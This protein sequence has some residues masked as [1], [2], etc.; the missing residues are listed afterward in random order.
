VLDEV[1][2]W[3]ENTTPETRGYLVDGG[4]AVAALLGGHV[5]GTVVTRALGARNFD[6]VLRLSG[7]APAGDAD[8]GFT[9]TFFAGLL[10]RLTAWVGGAWW[11]A[12]KHGYA[13]L[14]ATLGLV[15]RRGWALAAV[16][17]AALAL[18]GLLARR[19]LDCL[20]GPAK[21]GPALNGAAP[22]RGAAGAVAAG[23]YGLAVVLVLLVAADS[24][25]WPLTRSAALALWQFAQHLLI[26]CAALSIGCLGARWAQDLVAAGGSSS[27]E[28]SAGQYTGLGIVAATTV[29]AVTVLLSSAGVLIGL[30]A[31]ALL[32]VPLWLGRGHLPDVMAGLQLRAHKVREVW[33]EGEPWEVVQVGLVTSQVGRGGSFAQVQNRIVLEARMHGAPTEAAAR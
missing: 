11:L 30:A 1:T 29:L 28:K 15:L 18:G 24:F 4:L 3:W 31:L 8:R 17:V 7:P 23:A 12:N 27:P 9:P 22:N 19:L 16:L 20:Q 33:F 5:L 2:T 21:A 13:E 32:G 6:A 26:A 25:D 10:V 14:A